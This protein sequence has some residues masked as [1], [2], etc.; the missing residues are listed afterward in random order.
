MNTRTAFLAL[1]PVAVAL[2]AGAALPFQD[3]ATG[4]APGH[5]PW[6]TV[7]SLAAGGIIALAVALLLRLRTGAPPPR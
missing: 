7:V 6:G 2:L 5:P 4:A 3:A 1:L